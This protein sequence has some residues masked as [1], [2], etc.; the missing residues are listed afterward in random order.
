[1]AANQR[2]HKDFRRCARAVL[3]G[4]SD[5]LAPAFSDTAATRF[6]SEVYHSGPHNFSGC[7]HPPFLRWSW[8]AVNF[9]REWSHSAPSLLIGLGMSSLRNAYPCS[10]SC[11][12][13]AERSL[14]PLV[15]GNVQLLNSFP[16][17]Q[18]ERIPPIL[19]TSGLLYWHHVI[20]SPQKLL[21]E[22]HGI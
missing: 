3:D 14:P 20:V 11:L 15:S 13:P 4:K 8:S 17:A 19:P 2:C 6:F 7:H 9:L 22:V 21:A 12:T 1:M 5:R 16:K 10:L 18:G